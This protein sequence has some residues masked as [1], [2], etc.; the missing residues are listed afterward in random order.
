MS[1]Q[2]VIFDMDG[3]LFDSERIV[4]EATQQAADELNLPFNFDLYLRY[5]G[6]SDEEVVKGYHHELASFGKNRVD[7]FIQRA[8]Q[9]SYE[10]YQKG[11]VPL[12]KGAKELLEDLYKKEIPCVLASSNVRPVI[13]I[14]LEKAQIQKYF[15]GIF[16]GEK[17]THAKPDPEIFNQA[18]DFLSLPKENLLVLEDSAHGVTAAKRAG[19]PVYLVP[20]L[21][22]PTPQMKEEATAIFEDLL[23]V[24]N[25]L[26]I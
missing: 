4:Y 15:K 18:A 2:G 20:D 19:I 14:F 26:N 6:M 23:E 17:V 3:L 21:L 1:L 9:L 10:I 7:E 5:L 8:Y 16:S 11:E 25:F 24:K 12:K 13:D 22:I